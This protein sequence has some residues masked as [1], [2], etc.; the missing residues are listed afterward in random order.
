[1]SFPLI[2]WGMSWQNGI[3]HERRWRIIQ[4]FAAIA[5]GILLL[6]T[7]GS[8]QPGLAARASQNKLRWVV[9]ERRRIAAITSPN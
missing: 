6:V 8:C 5:D 2:Q 7:L 3:R 9:T 1:M 4:G